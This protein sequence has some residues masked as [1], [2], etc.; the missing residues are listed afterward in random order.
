MGE[1]AAQGVQRRDGAQHVAEAAQRAQHDHGARPQPLEG[2]AR[3]HLVARHDASP[4]PD[5][6]RSH[7]DVLIPTCDRPHALAVTLTSLTAQSYRPLRIVVSDQSGRP[8]ELARCGELQAVLRLLP[9]RGIPVRVLRHVPR[10][11]MAEQRQFLLDQADAP[12]VLFLDDDVI[13]EPDLVERL[14]RALCDPCASASS[15]ARSL[16]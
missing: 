13:L 16:V 14:E 12:A 1:R 4:A 15:A 6:A 10:R 3:P 9:V 2:V 7:V 8:D 11:G 5:G